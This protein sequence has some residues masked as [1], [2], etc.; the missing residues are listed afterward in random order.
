M[1]LTA[2]SLGMHGT[3]SRVLFCV[4]PAGNGMC[5]VRPVKGVWLRSLVRLGLILTAAGGFVFALALSA[6][7]DVVEPSSAYQPASTR[8]LEKGPGAGTTLP[9][10][11][12]AAPGVGEASP[13]A[14]SRDTVVP[15]T[16]AP[17]HQVRPAPARITRAEP[18]SHDSALARA[19]RPLGVGLERIGS[20]L[21]RVISTCQVVPGAGAGVP[22]LALGVLSVVAALDRRRVFGT[23]L[24]T[25]ED[26]PELL[27]AT[28]V[29]APG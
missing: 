1:G 20:Y 14:E 21:G 19:A 17:E 26:V 10:V 8:L 12:K 18:V 9:V 13:A 5:S 27:Y 11:E 24:T 3:A 4:V 7:A 6:S 2:S 25:D 23:R 16:P 22:V 29:I 15:A 28:E